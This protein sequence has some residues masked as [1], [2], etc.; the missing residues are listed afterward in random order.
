MQYIKQSKLHFLSLISN[1]HTQL[2]ISCVSMGGLL[3]II[4]PQQ[5]KQ[6]ITS[7]VEQKYAG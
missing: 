4:N 1:I 6:A 2:S 5:R 3:I 7:L